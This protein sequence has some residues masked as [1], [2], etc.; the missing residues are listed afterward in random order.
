MII[1]RSKAISTVLTTMIILVASIVL[2]VGV[3]I[4]GTS[5]FQTGAQQ[6][7]IAIH[8]VALWVNGTNSTG[9]AWGAAGVR[10]SGDKLVSVDTIQIRGASM[11]FTQ[12]Y[13]EKNQ[14]ALTTENFQSQYEITTMDLVNGLLTNGTGLAL[15]LCNGNAG[16]IMLDFDGASGSKPAIC[17]AQAAGPTS[18]TPGQKM[19]V[20]FRVNPGL[21]QPVD[22][23]NPTNVG[24]FAGKTGAPITTII[25]NP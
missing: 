10:N 5:L 14:T 16:I 17:L 6:E 8:G 2:A 25:A 19:I 18:L 4:Y 13:V 22:S 9:T 12:W 3:V 11:P 20:Y 24:I 7:S 1:R 23:G 15:G 21:L